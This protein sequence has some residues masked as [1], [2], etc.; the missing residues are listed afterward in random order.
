MP[1]DPSNSIM[2]LRFLKL[3]GLA[4]ALAITGSVYVI[5]SHGQQST[6]PSSVSSSS[7]NWIGCL[8]VGKEETMDRMARGA[9]PTAIGNIEI[10]LRSDGVVVWRGVGAAPLK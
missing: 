4:G 1:K 3:A 8:V 7:T 2:K 9:H 6:K 5:N 10:G